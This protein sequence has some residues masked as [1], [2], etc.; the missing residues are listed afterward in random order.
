LSCVWIS[1]GEGAAV[2]HSAKGE[3]CRR[4]QAHLV[5]PIIFLCLMQINKS[6]VGTCLTI[7]SPSVFWPY[8]SANPP[9]LKL[10]EKLCRQK[11]LFYPALNK[12]KDGF[13]PPT[14]LKGF[15]IIRL[16]DNIWPEDYNVDGIQVAAVVLACCCCPLSH[17]PHELRH[18]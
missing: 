16:D 1:H 4:A 15:A 11:R 17:S 13:F 10:K 5:G 18:G 6:V 3:R 12:Q 8:P 7:T 9:V 2:G 14:Y